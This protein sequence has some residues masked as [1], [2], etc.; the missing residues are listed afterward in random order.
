MPDT[1]DKLA[2]IIDS[3]KKAAAGSLK[4][5]FAGPAVGAIPIMVP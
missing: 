5:S 3:L 4:F 1:V 2:R